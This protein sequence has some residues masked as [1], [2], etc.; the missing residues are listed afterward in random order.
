MFPSGVEATDADADLILACAE[1]ADPMLA[2]S[3]GGWCLSTR[4]LLLRD[5]GTATA[6]GESAASARTR[7]LLFVKFSYIIPRN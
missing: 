2:Q 3:G 6:V 5:G 1:V 7:P 4:L